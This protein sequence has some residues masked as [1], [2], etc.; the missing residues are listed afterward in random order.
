MRALDIADTR[1]KLATYM[2]TGLLT[3][4]EMS[5]LQRLAEKKD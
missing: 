4:T 2:K 5:P 1:E 3:S